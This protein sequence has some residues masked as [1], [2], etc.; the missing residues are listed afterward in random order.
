MAINQKI[1]DE[2]TN[3][4]KSKEAIKIS[5]AIPT[6]NAGNF[7]RTTLTS[8]LEQ[9]QTPYEILVSDDGSTDR[10][11]SILEEY[12]SHPKIK[13]INLRRKLL[14]RA[15]PSL[16]GF[17]PIYQS[18]LFRP[19]LV[20]LFR[21][22]CLRRRQSDRANFTIVAIPTPLNLIQNYGTDPL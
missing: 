22:N 19:T 11:V 13:G 3:N 1:L 5:L 15:D 10:T 18:I 16:Q 2:D 4:I 20:A 21:A 9:V 14:H 7:I 8:C 6:Y 12:Q 17:P